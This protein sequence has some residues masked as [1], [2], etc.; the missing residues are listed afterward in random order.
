MT[1]SFDLVNIM[2]KVGPIPDKI[3]VFFAANF[4]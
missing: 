4:P 1:S 2:L 3:L